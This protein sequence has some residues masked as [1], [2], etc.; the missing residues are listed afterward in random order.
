MRGI[1]DWLF[2]TWRVPAAIGAGFGLIGLLLLAASVLNLGDDLSRAQKERDKNA[3]RIAELSGQ[4]KREKDQRETTT[5]RIGQL[6]NQLIRNEITP[7]PAPP[8]RSTTHTEVIERNNTTTREP[9]SQSTSPSTTTTTTAPQ[10][11]T[12]VAVLNICRSN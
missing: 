12:T 2:Q 9:S 7:E 5:Q 11:C 10:T 8:L 1:R 3:A 4:L 6:E